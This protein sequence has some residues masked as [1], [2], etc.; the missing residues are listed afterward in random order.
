VGLSIETD[1]KN[2]YKDSANLG[3]EYSKFKAMNQIP[4]LKEPWAFVAY[5]RNFDEE[6]RSWEYIMGDVVINLD[7]IP[8]GL[9][10][11]EIPPTTYAIF[12]I[13]AKFKFLWGVE[14]ARMKRYIF[15][16][17]LPNSKNK[18]TG[19]DFE[20]HDERSTGKN[21]SIDLFVE[22]VEGNNH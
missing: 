1:L 3:K 16:K 6:T 21:P 15:N 9:T 7:S 12:P 8:E 14:I 10:G 19:C 22:I 13:H 4:N 17:W 20:Y 18:S 5:S 11:Y 2:V